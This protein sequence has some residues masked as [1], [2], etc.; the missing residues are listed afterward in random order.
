MEPRIPAV[1]V[2]SPTIISEEG[3]NLRLVFAN[4]TAVEVIVVN[5]RKISANSQI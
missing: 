1:G 5:A 4:N 2:K 3:G